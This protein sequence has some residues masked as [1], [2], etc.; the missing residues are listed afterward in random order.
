MNKEFIPGAYCV[1]CENTTELITYFI[2]EWLQ[3]NNLRKFF[4]NFPTFNSVLWITSENEQV[5]RNVLH[6]PL[7]QNQATTKNLNVFCLKQSEDLLFTQELISI[8]EQMCIIPP[9]LVFVEN[10]EQWLKLDINDP[11]ANNALDLIQRFK[12]WCLNNEFFLLLPI[13]QELPIWSTC[14]HGLTDLNT[15][16][17]VLQTQWWRTQWGFISTLWHENP[18]RT[19]NSLIIKAKNFNNLGQ[20]AEHIHNRRIKEQTN[21]TII[22]VCDYSLELQPSLLILMGADMIVFGEEKLK[23]LGH[24]NQSVDIPN[25]QAILELT[26]KKGFETV[27]HET[28]S[29]GQLKFQTAKN[30]AAIGKLV[31]HQAKLW[32]FQ[33]SLSRVSLLSHISALQAAKLTGSYFANCMSLATNEALYL[34]HLNKNKTGQNQLDALVKQFFTAPIETLAAGMVHYVNNDDLLSIFN[35]LAHEKEAFKPETLLDDIEQSNKN[36]D[37]LWE[38]QIDARQDRP[39]LNRL[40]KLNRINKQ[41]LATTH[42]V[43]KVLP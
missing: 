29:P 34:F 17:Q 23:T 42:S 10:L 18:Q 40:K 20:M 5:I 30:F 9:S 1:R 41:T 38:N 14:T 31:C 33:A 28:V 27:F 4:Y 13:Q 25:Q 3:G 22:V 11:K 7:T 36:L 43:R 26:S 19:K 39:W 32:G 6:E 35:S 37:E 24:L 12:N 2:S 8:I 15:K 16:G 21:E